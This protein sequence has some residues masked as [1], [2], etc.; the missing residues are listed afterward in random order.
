MSTT[1][2]SPS[3][4]R[5][6]LER[7][8]GIGA[9]VA[10]ATFVVGIALYATTLSDLTDDIV[11]TDAVDFVV[12]HQTT[13][14]AWYA[15]IFL[16]FGVALVPLIRA[17][18]ERLRGTEP[19]LADT[20][21]IFGL[22]WVGLMFAT[23]MISNIG[24]AA[25]VDATGVGPDHAASVWASIDA[26]T[27]GLGGGN[28]LVGGLWVLLVSIAALR[29]AALPRSLNILGIVSALAGLVTVIPGLTD[30]GIIFGLGLI[31]WFIWLGVVLV[32]DGGAR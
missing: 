4:P 11:A 13:L 27:D 24:I 5:S 29:S 3:E 7:Q 30:V 15:T 18:R 10:G 32:R 28:E 16:V 12:G 17:L 9:I 14:F 6:R 19:G 1:L 8:G 25:V 20:S 23:G 2:I 31:V 22:I 26:V 21:A